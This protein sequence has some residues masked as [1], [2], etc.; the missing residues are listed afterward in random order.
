VSGSQ[1]AFDDITALMDGG[2][3]VSV[4]FGYAF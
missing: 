4:A 1:Q 2:V 3:I